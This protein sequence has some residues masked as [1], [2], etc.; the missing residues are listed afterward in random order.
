[1]NC[2]HEKAYFVSAHGEETLKK[3]KGHRD[4]KVFQK[5]TTDDGQKV[6][7]YEDLIKKLGK[8][9]KQSRDSGHPFP[10]LVFLQCCRSR[11]G[12]LH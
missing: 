8:V 11:R 7:V 2:F 9:A 6:D 12:N 4:K 3:Y 5:I 1:M 10:I